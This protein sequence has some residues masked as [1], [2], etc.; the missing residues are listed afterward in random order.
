MT[1]KHHLLYTHGFSLTK[2]KLQLANFFYFLAKAWI[3]G[4]DKIFKFLNYVQ[5]FKDG[6]WALHA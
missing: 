2:C 3:L 5:L 4:L 1:E 6:I